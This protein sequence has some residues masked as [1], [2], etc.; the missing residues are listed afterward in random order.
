MVSKVH[1]RA[2]DSPSAVAVA[3]M[4]AVVVDMVLRVDV[5]RAKRQGKAAELVSERQLV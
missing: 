3:S 2:H 5:E 1:G 4:E